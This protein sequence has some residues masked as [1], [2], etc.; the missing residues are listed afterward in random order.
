MSFC[1]RLV[2]AYKNSNKK[3][4]NFNKTM[5]AVMGACREMGYKVEYSC[6]CVGIMSLKIKKGCCEQVLLYWEYK[7]DGKVILYATGYL[8]G[9]FVE[10]DDP[11][12]INETILDWFGRRLICI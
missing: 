12:K 4:H 9:E 5:K 10:T 2:D 7:T 11:K 8:N 3:N 1:R 6:M